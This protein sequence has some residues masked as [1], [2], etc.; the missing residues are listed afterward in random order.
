MLEGGGR[1]FYT[2]S[3]PVQYTVF[4]G[5]VKTTSPY[6]V[7]YTVVYMLIGTFYDK[8]RLVRYKIK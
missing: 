1:K 2:Y 8:T 6:V 3:I 7:L 4:N 5:D